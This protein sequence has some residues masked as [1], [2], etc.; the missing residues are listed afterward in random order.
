[1]PRRK[2]PA[3]KSPVKRSPVKKKATPK[4]QVPP[5]SLPEVD[6]KA[7]QDDPIGDRNP[8]VRKRQKAEYQEQLT[9]LQKEYPDA[10]WKILESFPPWGRSPEGVVKEACRLHQESRDP[11]KEITRF[12]T[13]LDVGACPSEELEGLWKVEPDV[14]SVYSSDPESAGLCSRGLCSRG[15]TLSTLESRKQTIEANQKRL[16][17]WAFKRLYGIDLQDTVIGR[18][19]YYPLLLIARLY[20]WRHGLHAGTLSTPKARE[21]RKLLKQ[22]WEKEP[23]G[24]RGSGDPEWNW[25]EE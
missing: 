18:W 6:I 23:R 20:L 7:I 15:G 2:A 9:L 13:L 3:K 19:L 22:A 8:S 24:I 16:D 10:P 25:D 4:K 1:M 14:E 5:K 11:E 21:T 17:Q 12:L